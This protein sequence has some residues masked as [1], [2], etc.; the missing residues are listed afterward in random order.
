MSTK[1][2][3]GILTY[4]RGNFI[5]EIIQSIIEQA[6]GEIEIVVNDS[7]SQNN[8]ESEFSKNDN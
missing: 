7:V 5:G 3:I 8:T 4:N 1:L 2:S 6:T